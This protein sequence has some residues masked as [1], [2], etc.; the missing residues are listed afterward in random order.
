MS[1]LFDAI[2]TSGSGTITQSQFNHAFETKNPP[3]VFRHQGADA[4]FAALD[5][6]GTGEVSKRDFVLT[7]S[8]LMVSLRAERP[9]SVILPPADSLAVSLQSLSEIRPSVAPPSPMGRVVKLTV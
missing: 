9:S 2:D 4:I 8:G 3:A 5:P 1:S 7:M 6:N